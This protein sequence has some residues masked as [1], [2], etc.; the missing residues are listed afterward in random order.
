MMIRST[1]G[2]PI[3]D[4]ADVPAT[5]NKENPRQSGRRLPN[6]SKFLPSLL[7]ISG[8]SGFFPV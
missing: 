8:F 2:T 3:R 6:V 5:Q 1:A 4:A 7:K